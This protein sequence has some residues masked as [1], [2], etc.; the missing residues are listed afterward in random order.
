MLDDVGAA[1]VV[2]VVDL[3]EELLHEVFEGHDPG[4]AAVFVDDHGDLEAAPAQGAQERADA[5]GL[6]DLERLGHEVG[7]RDGAAAVELDAVRGLDV[8]DADD[9]V[10][11]L[12]QDGEAGVPGAGRLGDDVG[13]GRRALQGDRVDARG[14]DLSGGVAGEG[15]R[16]VEHRRLV[17]VERAFGGRAPDEE[18]ELLGAAGPRQLLLGLDAH[19]ADRAVRGAVEQD[20]ERLEHGGERDLERDHELRG[21]QRDRQREVLGDQFAEDHREQ[22]GDDDRDDRADPGDRALGDAEVQE[23]CAQERGDR[24]LEG[25]AGEERGEGD[26][27]LRGG[28][29][30][31]GDL[32]GLDGGVE[33]LLALAAAALQLRAV[34]VDEGEFGGHEQARADGQDDT[35]EDAPDF[36]AQRSPRCDMAGT[37]S[38]RPEVSQGL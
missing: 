36:R 23:R 27:E 21:R 26:A 15:E 13:G 25:V 8:R 28:E 31:G 5:R 3:A 29:V 12:P 20:H 18:A 37:G 6:G 32:E 16:A 33:A 14:H 1:P 7:D 9:V 19:R 11:V 22:R 38:G 35:R 4:G 17:A 2:L 30:G 10:H 24:G 34:E